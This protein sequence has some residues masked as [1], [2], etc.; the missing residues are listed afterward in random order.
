MDCCCDDLTCTSVNFLVV[1]AISDMMD[2][3]AERSESYVH[4]EP[5]R[6]EDSADRKNCASAF[7]IA[8]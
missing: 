3:N 2:C 4:D 6:V 5:D 7:N 8:S 1:V